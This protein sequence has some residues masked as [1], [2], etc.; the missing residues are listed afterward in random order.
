MHQSLLSP[1]GT[2]QS[3]KEFEIAS[4]EDSFAMTIILK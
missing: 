1:M 3:S 2:K 4:L